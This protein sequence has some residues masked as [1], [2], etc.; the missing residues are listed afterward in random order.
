MP[1]VGLNSVVVPSELLGKK[2]YSDVGVVNLVYSE[3]LAC[4]NASKNMIS[5][6]IRYA[7]YMEDNCVTCNICVDVDFTQLFFIN[8][9]YFK[10]SQDDT[11]IEVMVDLKSSIQ[12]L[13]VKGLIVDGAGSIPSSVLY[14]YEF[15]WSTALKSIEERSGISFYSEEVA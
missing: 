5:R 4:V 11:R 6:L 7:K 13:L 2:K 8:N 15:Y 9:I 10:F 1:L 14:E 12:H 3:R